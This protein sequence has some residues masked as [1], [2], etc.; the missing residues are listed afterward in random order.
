MQTW[1]KTSKRVFSTYPVCKFTNIKCLCSHGSKYTYGKDEKRKIISKQSL[2]GFP[3]YTNSMHIDDHFI[4]SLFLHLMP[5]KV[6]RELSCTWA[7]Q[8]TA[9]FNTRHRLTRRGPSECHKSK[10]RLC[11]S[12]QKA[13]QRDRLREEES[14]HASRTRTRRVAER[15]TLKVRNFSFTL[16]QREK[17]EN[18]LGSADED[19]IDKWRADNAINHPA[20]LNAES[21]IILWVTECYQPL[22]GLPGFVVIEGPSVEKPL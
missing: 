5:W 2:L 12:V 19:R 18:V 14:H 1:T 13:K 9:A 7:C 15:F 8:Q 17:W 20:W 16:Y 3:N 6:Q 10:L 21:N 22:C 4:C 11:W